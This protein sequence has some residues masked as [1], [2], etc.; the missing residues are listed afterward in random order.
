VRECTL[1]RSLMTRSTVARLTPLALAIVSIVKGSFILGTSNGSDRFWRAGHGRFL[2]P[3]AEKPTA[4]TSKYDIIGC[5]SDPVWVA[6][7]IRY[8]VILRY[9]KNASKNINVSFQSLTAS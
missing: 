4:Q 6:S 9:L 2:R 3:K 5:C 8:Q 1:D 7:K